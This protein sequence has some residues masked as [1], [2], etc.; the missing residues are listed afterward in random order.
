ME[1]N[2]IV[3]VSLNAPKEKIWGRL[4]ALNAAGVTVQGIDLNAFDDWVHQILDAQPSLVTLSTVFYP[5]HRVE[6]IALDEPTGE[7]PSLEQRFTTR[8]GITLIEYLQ[9]P[10]QFL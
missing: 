10:R 5:L 9:M 2:S 3:I 4:V 1:I 8:I 7:I 6:R